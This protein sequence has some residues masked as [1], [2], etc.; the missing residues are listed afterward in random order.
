MS[1]L[2][3]IKPIGNKRAKYKLQRAWTHCLYKTVCVLENLLIKNISDKECSISKQTD[4]DTKIFI[5]A[6]LTTF[7]KR[8][9]EVIYAIRSIMLQT[10]PPNQVILWLADTQFP[11][12]EIPRNL[13]SLLTN[14]LKVRFCDDLR[15]HKKY[16]YAL[17][18]QKENE[19]VI[20]FDDDIIY[21]PYTIERLVNKHAQYPECIICS[22]A[23]KVT[24][25]NDG[26]VKSYHEWE[27]VSDGMDRPSM[28]LS[29]LTGSGC[30]YPYAALSNE[31]FNKNRIKAL[32]FSADDLWIY[33]MSVLSGRKVCLTDRVAHTFSVVSNSQTEHLGIINCI[34][35]GNNK[36]ISTLQHE[37]P[38]AL[39][40]IL[41]A[42]SHEDSTNKCRS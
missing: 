31:A 22:S 41:D 27:N 36:V 13:T 30:L 39:K 38:D 16:Y 10:M 37:Y 19:V 15:S 42:I 24:L 18:E 28:V 34:G 11:N 7:P 40:K 12:K 9:H 17:Q 4:T 33:I 6:S 8:I 1:L 23:H 21:H 32:A 29:P 25:S 35:D 2:E 14:G 3:Q 5:T 26:R 20:T